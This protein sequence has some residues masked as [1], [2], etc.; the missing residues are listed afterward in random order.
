M[1]VI[2]P[3]RV[4]MEETCK[5]LIH[6]LAE[7][8]LERLGVDTS[9]YYV[10]PANAKAAACKGCFG[11]WLKTPGKCVYQD[12]FQ[13]LG[14]TI[15][16]CAQV[17]VISGNCY[18]GYS[19]VVK[20]CFDRG[21]SSSLPFF[22]YRGGR[23]HHSLRYRG[24][25]ALTVY[26]YGDVNETERGIAAKLVKANGCNMGSTDTKCVFVGDLRE[27]KEKWI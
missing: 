27:L 9:G 12:Q 17:T 10:I 24:K 25:P 3:E 22:T 4:A 21:I 16:Q 8:E 7:G 5:L 14:A 18:G 13:Y 2:L 23:I 11:C 15:A 19:P 6:D 20:R 26:F 1:A